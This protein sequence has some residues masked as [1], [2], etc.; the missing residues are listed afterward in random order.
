MKRLLNKNEII[1]KVSLAIFIA[2]ICLML[3]EVFIGPYRSFSGSR[4]YNLYPFK[5]IIDFYTNEDKYGFSAV[6]INLIANV[7]TF[8]PLGFFLPLHVYRLH[9]LKR[10]LLSYISIIV[11][12]EIM[13]YALNV[14]VLDVDDIILNITGSILGYLIFKVIFGKYGRMV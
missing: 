5:T 2:Y 6:F 9:N 7:I 4:R 3:W 13:Q 11:S 10:A 12:I 1:Y 8:I 14:G